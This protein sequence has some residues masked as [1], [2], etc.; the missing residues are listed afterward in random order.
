MKSKSIFLILTICGLFQMSSCKKDNEI[1]IGTFKKLSSNNYICYF[2]KNK[3]EFQQQKYICADDYKNAFTI[4]NDKKIRFKNVELSVSANNEDIHWKKKF[5]SGKYQMIIDMFLTKE[6]NDVKQ[7]KGTIT[8]KSNDGK[9]VLT[10][11]YG[12]CEF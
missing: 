11:F 8:I 7:Q 2:A 6:I 4:I 3:T 10:T 1:R 5:K 9:Q 12:E